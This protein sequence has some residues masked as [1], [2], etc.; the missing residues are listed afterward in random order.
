MR[1]SDRIAAVRRFNRFYTQKIGVL[2]EGLLESPFSLTEVRVLYELA[3][4]AQP[5]AAEIVRDLALD[6]G[7]LSR[8]LRRFHQ[9]G[10]VEKRA[11]S[12]DGRRSILRLTKKGEKEFHRVNAS[13]NDQIGAILS[14]LSPA[15]QMRL[16]DALGTVEELLG[17]GPNQAVPNHSGPNGAGRAR[18]RRRADEARA[19]TER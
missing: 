3:H 10:L 11:S 19:S 5:T 1:V 18:R 9:L 12:Q 13:T 15:D 6:A 17:A 16:L 7:Y 2:D 14:G 4:R 8:I